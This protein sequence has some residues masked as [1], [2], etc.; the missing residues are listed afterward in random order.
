MKAVLF[1]CILVLWLVAAFAKR[2]DQDSQLIPGSLPNREL[3]GYFKDY[4]KSKRARRALPTADEPD[5]SPMPVGGDAADLP[6]CLLCVCLTGSVY[7]E[8][9][10]PDMTSVPTLP[11]ETA[12]LYARFNKIKKISAKDFGDIVTLKRIDLS[13]NMISEIEDGAFS[14]LTILEE[15]SLADNRLVKLPT[16]P[17]KLTS[18]NA[19]HNFL[20]TKGVKANAFKNNNITEVNKETFCKSNNTYYLRLSLSEIRLDGNPAMLSKYPDSFTCMK[21]LPVGRYR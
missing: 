14:K 7:C 10:S 18:F 17:A 15:L 19:N 13:G 2:F 8:D 3:N 1:T 21:V 5:A 12:Y 6:T 4:L 11:K 9:V 16:L 20:K